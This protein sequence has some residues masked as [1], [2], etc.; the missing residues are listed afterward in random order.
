MSDDKKLLVEVLP[1]PRL[2]RTR[3]SPRERARRRLVQ[4]TNAAA[5]AGIGL[6]VSYC[7][8][9]MMPSPAGSEDC[10][11]TG[12]DPATDL[13]IVATWRDVNPE[14]DVATLV[15]QIDA[16]EGYGVAIVVTDGGEAMDDSENPWEIFVFAERTHVDVVVTVDSCG[17]RQTALVRFDAT[18]RAEDA[19]VPFVID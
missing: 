4:L 8:V 9:D 6:S 2:E 5:T 14:T 10:G 19:A 3:G 11:D 7:V 13:V 17:S 18:T 1:T 12:L 15:L 16:P